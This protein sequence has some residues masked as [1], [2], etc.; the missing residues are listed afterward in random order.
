MERLR[1]GIGKADTHIHTAVG[2]GM[3]GIPRLLEHV[4][5]Q[6]DLDVIAI[7]DHDEFAGSYQARELVERDHYRFDVVMGME[8]TTLNGHL[9][10]LYLERPVASFQPLAQTIESIHAQ[11]GIC[12]VP[13][14]MSWLTRSIGQIAIEKVMAGQDERLYFDGIEVI[15]PTIAGMVSYEKT[16]QLNERQFKLA[17]TGGSDAHFLASVGSAYTTFVG[18]TAQDL[19]QSLVDKKTRAVKG[20][21]V[22][23]G[24][25]GASQII[26]QSC[27]GLF[28]LPTRIVRRSLQEVWKSYH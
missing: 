25:I 21:R 16:R 15:N 12:V 26:R 18:H 5:E 7:T 23:F 2:D 20:H 22:K 10:A 6:T 9:L 14:P 8:V 27:R 4:E 24:H 11:D 1:N 28:V 13:H 3:Y 17:E 19:R